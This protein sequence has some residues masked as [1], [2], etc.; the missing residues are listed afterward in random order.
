MYLYQRW[1]EIYLK[2]SGTLRDQRLLG[3]IHIVEVIFGKR[4]FSKI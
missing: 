4:K 2:K 1:T 3:K